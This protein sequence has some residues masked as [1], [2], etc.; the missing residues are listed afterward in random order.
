MLKSIID[1]LL[2][3]CQK[4]DFEAFLSPDTKLSTLIFFEK[5]FFLFQN[6]FWFPFK[7]Y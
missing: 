7:A 5:L 6:N 2:K 1:F 3:S 4:L